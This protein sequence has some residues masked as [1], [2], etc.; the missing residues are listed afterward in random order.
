M[1]FGQAGYGGALLGNLLLLL[2][3]AVFIIVIAL[4]VP[5]YFIIRRANRQIQRRF[6]EYQK[7]A[8]ETHLP[9]SNTP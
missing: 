4:A 5:I 8:N 6:E 9:P 2:L 7:T 1:L 3:G